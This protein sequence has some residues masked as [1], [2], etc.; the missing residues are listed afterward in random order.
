MS[1]FISRKDRHLNNREKTI[2]YIIDESS[3]E[4]WKSYYGN[5]ENCKVK[6]E[7]IE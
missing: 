4:V 5:I 2:R 7:I 1:K 3:N 6:Y